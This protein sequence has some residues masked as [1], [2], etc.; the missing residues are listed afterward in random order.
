MKGNLSGLLSMGVWGDVSAH[1]GSV[2]RG[3]L[4][5]ARDIVQ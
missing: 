5:R 1:A 4:F 3:M 2:I